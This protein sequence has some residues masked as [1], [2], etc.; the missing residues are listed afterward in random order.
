M[1]AVARHPPVM[2]FPDNTKRVTAARSDRA[3]G[4]VPVRLLAGKLIPTTC[5]MV[6]DTP[7]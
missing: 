6:H 7:M 2:G 4:R 5:A 1:A 3:S